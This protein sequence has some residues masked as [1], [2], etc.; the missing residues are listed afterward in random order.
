MSTQK[1]IPP[2]QFLLPKRSLLPS[3]L[4]LPSPLPSPFLPLP[5]PSF[6]SFLPPCPIII[7][8]SQTKPITLKIIVKYF[9]TVPPL[10]PLYPPPKWKGD[11]NIL[12]IF[13]FL[14]VS[15]LHNL[16]LFKFGKNWKMI[17]EVVGT[18]MCSQV[19]SHAQKYFIKMNK[20]AK[21][22]RKQKNKNHPLTPLELE[23]VENFTK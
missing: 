7:K 5:L 18:R 15:S 6:L 1:K 23:I 17:E 16:G 22:R 13:T 21:D 8:C 2:F 12:N 11:G 20:L 19:R 4:P 9:R 14:K 3:S 10:C